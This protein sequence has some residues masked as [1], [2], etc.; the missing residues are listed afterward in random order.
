MRLLVLYTR[1]QITKDTGLLTGL[2]GESARNVGIGKTERGH[3]NCYLEKE[4][5]RGRKREK[6]GGD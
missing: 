3:R 2:G 1:G 6:E 4:G 5:E